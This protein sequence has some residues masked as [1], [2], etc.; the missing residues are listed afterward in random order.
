MNMNKKN[1]MSFAIDPDIQE[2]IK[3][4]AARKS[5]PF[6]KIIRDLADKFLNDEETHDMIVLKVP[7]ELR[8]TPEEL[9]KWMEVKTTA[10]FN[11]LIKND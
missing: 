2:K 3:K 5:Q 1:V 11:A 6:S 4:V 7:K 9:K 8:T 10:I